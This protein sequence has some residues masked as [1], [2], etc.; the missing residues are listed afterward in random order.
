[1]W[2]L[3]NSYVHS[4]MVEI[5][6][7][8]TFRSKTFLVEPGIFE[9][10]TAEFP[11]HFF[12]TNKFQDVVRGFKKN[13]S[14]EA[15]V[16]EKE[17]LSAVIPVHL[18]YPF[19]FFFEGLE[20][21]STLIVEVESKDAQGEPIEQEDG[22][23]IGL[24]YQNAFGKYDNLIVESD[25][26]AITLAGQPGKK[27]TFKTRLEGTGIDW[28]ETENKLTIIPDIGSEEP[29]VVRFTEAAYPSSV[30]IL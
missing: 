25:G 29:G 26:L 14:G 28:V 17:V 21:R 9:T 8:R 4:M 24:M 23:I 6:G 2:P 18:P 7:R 11:L 1:M 3:T 16:S 22:M 10:H 12:R 13:T 30:N 20:S 19:L 5:P 27:I 15:Y